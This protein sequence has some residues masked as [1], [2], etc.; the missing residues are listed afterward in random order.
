VPAALAR[1]GRGVLAGLLTGVLV[2]G[3]AGCTD[4]VEREPVVDLGFVPAPVSARSWAPA[5]VD[6]GAGVRAVAG[7]VGNQFRLHTTGGEVT[8]LPG[9]DLGATTPGHEPGELSVDEATYRRWFSLMGQMGVRVVRIYTIHPPGFYTELRAYNEAHRDAPLYLM[10]GVYLPDENY[11]TSGNLYDPTS[12]AAFDAEILDAVAAVHGDLSR[13]QRPGRAHGRWTGDVSAWTVGWIAGVEWDPAATSA[14]DARNVRAPAGSG[15]YFTTA[16]EATPTERWIAA[17]LETLAGGLVA[18]GALAPLAFTN[19]PTTDPLRHPDEPLV[20]E[21]L[22][23]IDANRVRPTEAWRGG[24]FASYHVYP[25]YPDF[26]RYQP[27]L[28]AFEHHGT[29]NAYVGYLQALRDHHADLPVMITEFGVPASLGLTHL[30]PHGRDQG[31]HSEQEAIAMDATMLREIHD[32]GLA[33][34]LLFVWTDEWFKRTWN[35]VPRQLPAER[36][37]V[38]HDPLT[39]EQWFGLLAQDPLP[40]LDTVPVRLSAEGI[41]LT[42]EH[43]PGWVTLRLTLPRPPDGP[44]TLGFDVVPGGADTLPDGTLD[45]TSDYAVPL[46]PVARTGTVYV[47][48]ALDAVPLDFSADN[49][50]DRGTGPWVLSQLTTNR[51]LTVPITGQRLPV[52]L[53]DVGRLRTG[54]MAPG[55]DGYDSRNTVRFD[56]RSVALRLPWAMLGLADPSSR[57]ALLPGGGGRQTST[58]TVQGIAISVT[59]D[60]TQVPLGTFTWSSWNSVRAGERVKPGMQVWVDALAAVSG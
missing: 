5:P 26:L 46:D 2:A 15:R 52:E 30:G 17:R 36:R 38:W 42:V 55:E 4:A 27:D 20:N 58:T 19:W 10:A 24:Y 50:P 3:L 48:R 49:V 9:V 51:A 18:R 57:Q 1:G 44:V 13:S 23:Q 31:A 8:F 25:Y 11:V 56:G 45:A 32:L 40:A 60:H 21:D 53:F 39:S 22:E 34:G 35:T 12:T 6:L 37:A 41:E 14:S 7:T 28:V 33:G 29:A 43:D 47:R 16:A 54:P 59:A